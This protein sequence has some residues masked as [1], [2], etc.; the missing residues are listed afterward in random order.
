MADDKHK[1]CMS[2]WTFAMP[3][4]S[5]DREA[6]VIHGAAVT[7]EGVAEGHGVSL[8]SEFIA[9][10]VKLGN[11]KT[12]G[13]KVRFG[14][15]TMSSTALGTFLGRAKNFRVAGKTARA[16]I[17]LSNEAADAPG[18]NLRDYVLGMAANESD[19]FGM[20]VVF[21]RGDLY[22]R[23]D[24]GE[25]VTFDGDLER[26][27]KT[28]FVEM[29]RL[30][31]AD[32]VDEPAANADGLFGAWNSG[33]L[34]EQVT[35]FLDL[36]PQVIELVAKEPQ[37]I[38]QFMRRYEAFA[39]RRATREADAMP[40]NEAIEEI[41]T[42]EDVD[43]TVTETLEAADAAPVVE[44]EPEAVAL[45]AVPEPDPPA[46]PVTI[47]RDEMARAVDEFG[48]TA[49]LVFLNGGGYDEA[50]ELHFEALTTENARLTAAL[51]TGEGTPVS[52][53]DAEP[54][55]AP[56]A[57]PTTADGLTPGQRAFAANIR[58]ELNRN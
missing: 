22:T 24:D 49:A 36:H 37:V 35:E 51:A 53:L 30:H 54:D 34:A 17:F 2:A 8:D 9:Q 52:V 5:V 26:T 41:E 14:H 43:E 1:W 15:P 31:A 20:S 39:A 11:E 40:D 7:S 28:V 47:D 16:D 13:V 45:E 18:G 25:K 50:R 42:V 23:D 32:M 19:A 56:G 46:T 21:D 6:G 55:N 27:K 10:A 38:E 44:P 58:K 48:A 12:H 3:P 4:E 29:A 33:T 57:T